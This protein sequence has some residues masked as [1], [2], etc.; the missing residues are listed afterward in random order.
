[1]KYKHDQEKPKKVK[2]IYTQK[3]TKMSENKGQEVPLDF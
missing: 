2:P 3:F 1:M